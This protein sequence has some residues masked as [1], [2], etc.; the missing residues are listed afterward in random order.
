MTF[1]D[2]FA[3]N[4]EAVKLLNKSDTVVMLEERGKTRVNAASEAVKAVK[5]AVKEV[6]GLVIMG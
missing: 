6:K 3:H 2:D 4:P 5:D 1:A